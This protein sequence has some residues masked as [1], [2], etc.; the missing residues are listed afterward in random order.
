M[1]TSLKNV[2]EL[3]RYTVPNIL[4]RSSQDKNTKKL[5]LAFSIWL[6]SIW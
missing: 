3:A 6:I 4:T 5:A 1:L 2:L